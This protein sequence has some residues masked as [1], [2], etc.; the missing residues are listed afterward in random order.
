MFGEPAWDMLLILYLEHVRSRITVSQLT[1]ESGAA[2][3]TALRWIEYLESQQLIRR[4]AHPTDR[5]IAYL[6]LTDKAIQSL[7]TF[8]SE[9]LSAGA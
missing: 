8:L 7:E 4:Y 1:R 2:Q 9:T 6:D 3:T 5:R